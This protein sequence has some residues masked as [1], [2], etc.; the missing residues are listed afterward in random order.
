MSSDPF[1]DAAPVSASR[2]LDLNFTAS[3]A[4]VEAQEIVSE[5][6]AENYVD[7]GMVGSEA[8]SNQRKEF[9]TIPGEEGDV[10]EEKKV[11]SLGK[12]AKRRGRPRKKPLLV[13]TTHRQSCSLPFQDEGKVEQGEDLGKVAKRRGRPKKKSFLVD[14]THSDSYSSPF[15]GESKVEKDE[16][17]G[18]VAKRRGRPKKKSLLVDSTHSDSYSSPFQDE[19]KVEKDEDSGKV[20]KRRGRPKKQPHLPEYSYLHSYFSPFQDEN[21]GRFSV[22]DLVWGKVKSHPWWPGQIFHPSC[23]SEMASTHEKKDHFLVAYFGDKTFAWNDESLLK[24][25]QM[26]FSQMEKQSSVEAFVLAVDASLVEVTR[27]VELAMASD[28]VD[29]LKDQKVENAGLREG[30]KVAAVD[31]SFI[32]NS[33]QPEKFLEYILG[34]AQLPTE[35]VDRLELVIAKAQLTAFNRSKGYPDPTE[36]VMGEGMGKNVGISRAKR[37]RSGK[38]DVDYLE[39]PETETSHS[40]SENER[41]RHIGSSSKDGRK[42]RR[43]SDLTDKRDVPHS[44]DGGRSGSRVRASSRLSGRKCKVYDSDSDSSGNKKK[45]F[46]IL[47]RKKLP[48]TLTSNGEASQKRPRGRPRKNAIADDPHTFLVTKMDYSSPSEMLSQLCL[49]ATDPTNNYSFLSTIVSFFTKYKDSSASGCSDDKELLEIIGGR[50]GKRRSANSELDYPEVSPTSH[51][52]DSYW[53]D[54]VVSESA[55]EESVS[56][57]QKRKRG[58]HIKGEKKNEEGLKESLV[59]HSV[60]VLGTAQELQVDIE[61]EMEADSSA[62]NLTEKVEVCTPTSL[63][64]HFNDSEALPSES[65]LIKFFSRYGPLRKAET[66]ILKEAS[67]ARVVFNRRADAEV[68][69]S[70]AGKF[71]IFGRALVSYRLNYS[72]TTPKASSELQDNKEVKPIEGGNPNAPVQENASGSDAMHIEELGNGLSL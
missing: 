56:R 48:A 43:L 14:S 62:N 31:N 8:E 35:G 7:L 68:A 11:E 47:G 18:K 71:S 54:I 25:F 38:S 57:G 50:N 16:S 52:K 1:Y 45:S 22:T 40:A 10:D 49:S 6:L 29:T 58:S 21:K 66:E 5:T 69:F 59:L 41:S 19:N 64:L 61:H 70:S 23:A 53:S 26:N 42:K 20:L 13:E 34:L 27:R 51:M 28:A 44:V 60:P 65:D 39:S 12:V 17:L 72:Q 55:E 24:P 67:D 63:I 37:K 36:F 9:D 2:G 15:Q 46:D 33:F 3:G 30:T 32:A 4:A